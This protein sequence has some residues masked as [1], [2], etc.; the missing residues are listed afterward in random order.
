MLWQEELQAQ[1]AAMQAELSSLER[2][3]A[4]RNSAAAGLSYSLA[5]LRAKLGGGSPAEET[6]SPGAGHSALSSTLLAQLG[7]LAT[8]WA[9]TLL[10]KF[11]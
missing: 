7:A 9:L 5:D 2:E 11:P 1:L 8:S 4:E 10:S 3:L 6:H